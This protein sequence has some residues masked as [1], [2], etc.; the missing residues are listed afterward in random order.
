MKRIEKTYIIDGLSIT[1]KGIS[2]H[3][4]GFDL[5]TRLQQIVAES[6]YIKYWK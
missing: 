6:F 4:W 3:S 2:T 5:I 1:V